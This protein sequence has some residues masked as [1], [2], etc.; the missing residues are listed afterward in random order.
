MREGKRAIDDSID[1]SGSH[2]SDIV[3]LGESYVGGIKLGKKED[4]FVILDQSSDDSLE[5][6][7]V[8]LDETYSHTVYSAD[9]SSEP[10][11]NNKQGKF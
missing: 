1:S 2:E 5:D 10:R 4:N 11:K 3:L 9:D 7:I 6:D 8:F